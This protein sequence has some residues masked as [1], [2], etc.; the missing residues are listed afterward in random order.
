[1]KIM[2][3]DD[4]ADMRRVLRSIVSF[5]TVETSEIIECDSGEEAV[6]KYILQQPDCVLMD[7]ELK[8]MNGFE[9]T[10]KIYT[11]DSNAN[12]VIV[13]SYD[14]TAFR[15]RAEKLHVK[16]FISKDKLSDIKQILQNITYNR[17]T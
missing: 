10:E 4:H 17:G 2:I 15:S 9:T 3:V 14:T 7:V 11:Q 13:T 16:G 1:M 8:G 12:V 6:G 5:S